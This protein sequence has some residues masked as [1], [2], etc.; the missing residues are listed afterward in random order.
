MF[1]IQD[2]VVLVRNFWGRLDEAI[3]SYKSVLSLDCGNA[4]VRCWLSRSARRG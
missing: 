2:V 3:L 4:R 1:S